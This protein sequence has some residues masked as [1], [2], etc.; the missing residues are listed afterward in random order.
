VL[1]GIHSQVALFYFK[2]EFDSPSLYFDLIKSTVS[3]D[4]CSLGK[5]GL[6]GMQDTI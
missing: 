2:F 4:A 3:W 5:K 1:F 6:D